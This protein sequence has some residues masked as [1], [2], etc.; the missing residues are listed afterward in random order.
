MRRAVR[1]DDTR[2]PNR[3]VVAEARPFELDVGA[4][5]VVRGVAVEPGARLTKRAWLVPAAR[6][7][8]EVRWIRHK[9]AL[10]QKTS[11]GAAMRPLPVGDADFTT[12]PTV[13]LGDEPVVRLGSEEDPVG[14]V[15]CPAR[16]GVSLENLHAL[17][18][19][20]HRL[21]I[22]TKPRRG[23][24]TGAAAAKIT[25]AGTSAIATSATSAIGRFRMKQPPGK[26]TAYVDELLR[27]LGVEVDRL[28]V[29]IEDAVGTNVL[30]RTRAAFAA[31]GLRRA[32]LGDLSPWM[33]VGTSMAQRALQHVDENDSALCLTG[34]ST[35]A[36]YLFGMGGLGYAVELD[37]THVLLFD[38]R[39]CLHGSAAPPCEDCVGF[40]LYSRNDHVDA[41]IALENKLAAD[42]DKLAYSGS[43][44]ER[45]AARALLPG[46]RAIN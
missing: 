43:A 22:Q 44:G 14:F 21:G 32:L 42:A 38:A 10:D 27:L 37:R 40:S 16:M 19:E 1:L 28:T 25:N 18:S 26:G 4:S 39:I 36:P 35:E 20:L 3:R 31:A 12:L 9:V 5:A 29:A 33:S 6:R 11:A 17:A 13:P 7:E 15:L 45:A 8:A 24:A 41:V 30:T 2:I 46:R 34:V 23:R